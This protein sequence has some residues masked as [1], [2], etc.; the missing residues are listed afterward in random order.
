[1]IFKHPEILYFLTLLGVPILVH[2][3][4][5]RRFKK[6][7][8]TNVRFL[9][10]ILIETQKS[11]KLKKWLLLATR[12]LLLA[13]IV[14]A[15]AQPF[16]KTSLQNKKNAET[17]IVLDHSFS[18]QTK[19]QAG[20]L[21]KRAIE[22]ILSH[23]A[24]NQTVSIITMTEKFWDI[25][26]KT[27]QNELQ[28]LQYSSVPFDCN[29]LLTEIELKK[30]ATAKNICIITDAVNP[31]T[32]TKL[33]IPENTNVYIALQKPENNQNCAINTVTIDKISDTFYDLKLE[34]EN[35]SDES[36][37]IPVS[38][39]DA[40]KQIAKT[41]VTLKKG[42]NYTTFTIPKGEF[43]GYAQITDNNLVYDNTLYFSINKPEK[44][45]IL[46]IGTPENNE[47]LTRIFTEDEFVFTQN[48]PNQIDYAAL[49][50]QQI[51]IV[52]EVENPTES[53]SK[54]VFNSYQN[55][56]AVVFIPH[57]KTTNTILNNFIK[58]FT[59]TQFTSL[60]TTEQQL[61]KIS[62]QHPLYKNVFEKSIKNFQY[63]SLK[64]VF[65]YATSNSLP[66]LQLSDGKNFLSTN[67]NQLN[68][69]Y[70]FYTPLNQQV[71]NFKNSPLIVPTFYAMA[72]FGSAQ[73]NLFYSIGTTNQ[74]IVNEK[75]TNEAVLTLKNKEHTLVPQQQKFEQKTALTFTDYIEHAG[76]FTLYNQEKPIKNL[77]FN[78]PRTES[79]LQTQNTSVYDDFEPINSV[80]TFFNN[81]TQN[82]TEQGFWKFFVW[83]TLLFLV[84]EL[85]IQKF[86]K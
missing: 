66:A 13:C 38:L 68:Y 51:I 29:Q 43:Q 75:A 60:N 58:P 7:Y 67:Y 12:L 52:N 37:Q 19:G 8:F 28:N 48:Q 1:M 56:S 26:P 25:E 14:L 57:E 30:P 59:N 4:Q 44:Q 70:L 2:L 27:I 33:T 74:L 15:F 71:T 35:F 82:Q 63:P 64:K 9:K 76:N 3:L 55:G 83:L 84:A 86:V 24:E 39:V 77:S 16:S 73:Q 47:F 53:L 40:D 20:E 62:F 42:K 46:A 80:E 41:I 72:Q 31:I 50:K 61:T 45:Q 32:E 11:S 69:F 54:T 22:D 17:I 79:N 34:I 81:L 85:F 21:L 78:Y 10:E 36:L 18:M 5:L 65:S 23:S 6:E 49:E